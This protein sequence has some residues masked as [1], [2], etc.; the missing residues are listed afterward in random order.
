MIITR[1]RVNIS[2]DYRWRKER[3]LHWFINRSEITF[4]VKEQ[5]VSLKILRSWIESMSNISFRL[6]I[7]SH[8][9]WESGCRSQRGL[10]GSS[11]GVCLEPIFPSVPIWDV[12]WY[13]WEFH[14]CLVECR[15]EDIVDGET[16]ALNLL[17]SRT[18]K[19][20]A[21]SIPSSRGTP[22]PAPTA[23]V[24]PLGVEHEVLVVVGFVVTVTVTVARGASEDDK[25]R[26]ELTAWPGMRKPAGIENSWELLPQSFRS[27]A[28]WPLLLQ[29]QTPLIVPTSMYVSSH[30][31]WNFALL[32]FCAILGAAG[33]LKSPVS[34]A[35]TVGCHAAIVK[36]ES[37][38]EAVMIRGTTV[39][40]IIYGG[41]CTWDVF[42]RLVAVGPVTDLSCCHP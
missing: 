15:A 10:C 24:V 29:A 26:A 9:G 40:V 14:C 32:T 38:C 27:H 5:R 22:M 1:L 11:W 30:P 34:T 18:K 28:N 35:A 8:G 17:R 3:N 12:C 19:A 16:A 42:I 13:P 41:I 33:R 2:D 6:I 20:M 7:Y 39:G 31:Y 21:A 25:A 4:Q 37:V 23:A 36:T